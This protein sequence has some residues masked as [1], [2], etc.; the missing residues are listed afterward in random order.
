MGASGILEHDHGDRVLFLFVVTQQLLNIDV[1]FVRL[2]LW[3]VIMLLDVDLVMRET[4][5]NVLNV[6]ALKHFFEF[7]LSS[8]RIETALV[9]LNR[10]FAVLLFRRCLLAVIDGAQC[11]RVLSMVHCQF[12]VDS[13]FVA[14]E[15]I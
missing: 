13:C 4:H 2:R 14:L 10:Q 8:K 11:G 15:L 7:V 9:P 6:E 12:F 1:E 5:F 3:V